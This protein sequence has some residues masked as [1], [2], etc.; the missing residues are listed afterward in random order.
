MSTPARS[1]PSSFL[2]AWLCA[3]AGLGCPAVQVKPPE[4]ADC[5]QEAIKAMFQELKLDTISPLRAVV[6]IN[7]PLPPDDMLNETNAYGIYQDGPVIGRITEGDGNLPEGTLLHGHLWT[8]P[9]I[10]ESAGSVKLPAVMGRYTQAVLPDG[11]KYPVCIV[12]G[13]WDGRVP[14]K[15]EGSKADAA[16]IGRELPVSVVE[17]WP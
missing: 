1:T 2:A 14:K 4:P 15:E 8:G 12:L 9:G 7:Q 3:V 13:S 17:R 10:Y 11:R 16:V 6:D 5:P